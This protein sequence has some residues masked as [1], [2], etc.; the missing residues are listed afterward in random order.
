MNNFSLAPLWHVSRCSIDTRYVTSLGGV[1]SER[2]RISIRR[3]FHIVFRLGQRNTFCEKV[4]RIPDHPACPG[5]ILIGVMRDARVLLP[6][7]FTMAAADSRVR[8]ICTAVKFAS[9]CKV[10]KKPRH[11]LRVKL[12]DRVFIIARCKK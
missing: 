12:F 11:G 6:T 10:K 4:K 9:H 1:I 7:Y 2:Y 5:R 8:T 3:L